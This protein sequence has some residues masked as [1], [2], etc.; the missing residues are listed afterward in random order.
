MSLISLDIHTRRPLNDGAPFGEVGPYVQLDGRAHFAVDPGHPANTAI[1][2]IGLA[3][4]DEQGRVAFSADFRIIQPANPQS[5]NRRLLYEVVNRGNPTALRQFNDAVDGA[6]PASPMEPGNGFLMRQ[7]YTLAWC[8]WQHDVPSAP[9]RLTIDVPEARTA[10]GPVSGNIAVTFQPSADSQVQQLSDR[11]HRPYP[12]NN[13]EDWNSVLT[14]R[15][16]DYS[17][18]RPIPREG[19]A[20]GRLDSGRFVPGASHIYMSSGFQAGKV[21]QVIYSTSYAPVVG[22]G[23]LATRD[24]VSFLRNSTEANPCAGAAERAYAFGR[25]QSGRFLRVYLYHGLNRDEEGRP[26]FD[27]LIPLVAGGRRGEFNYRFG[28]PSPHSAYSVNN[29]FPF[30]DVVQADPETGQ[31]GGL[32]SKAV[33]QGDRPRIFFINTSAEYWGGHASLIHTDVSGSSDVEPDENVRVYHYAGTQHGPGNIPLTRSEG[34]SRTAHYFNTVDYRPLLRA[35]LTRLDRWVSAGEPPP[36]SCHARIDDGTAVTQD[37]VGEVIK[38]IPGAR[39][40]APLPHNSRLDFGPAEG[41]FSQLPPKVGK[42]YPNLV[43]AVDRD[44]NELKGIRL[45]AVSVPLATHAGWNLRHESMGG[46]GQFI[47]QIG[48]TFP[49]PATRR[50]REETGDPRPSIEERYQSKDNYLSQVAQAARELVNQGYLLEE[51]VETVKAHA[52]QHYDLFS[53]GGLLSSSSEQAKERAAA[54]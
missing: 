30:T 44:G 21:Y 36:A 53:R 2:D 46:G 22:L 16:D 41:L 27:G 7:G 49:F 51:D 28:Q 9:G 25:S 48:S 23:L 13:L 10:D 38:G 1:T 5:G 18:P 6:D 35:A 32:L 29:L 3:P 4:T 37:Q 26:V 40:P 47:K 33:S 20:F 15:D 12:S 14:V 45:P 43:P 8:G 31:T 52:A 50:E 19:W 17:P 24:L 42:P 39:L 54:G 34:D 11:L